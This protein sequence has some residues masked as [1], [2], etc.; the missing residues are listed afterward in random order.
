MKETADEFRSCEE[1]SGAREYL[2]GA[3]RFVRAQVVSDLF[4][5]DGPG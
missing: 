3:T 4:N 1:V 2:R 5:D